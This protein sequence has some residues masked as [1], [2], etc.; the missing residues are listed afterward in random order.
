MSDPQVVRPAEVLGVER[1]DDDFH[2]SAHKALCNQHDAA[3]IRIVELERERDEA[4]DMLN[5]WH[6]LAKDAKP[7]CG[8]IGDGYL[9]APMKEIEFRLLRE[10]TSAFLAK[11]PQPAKEQVE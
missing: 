3:L 4:R 6:E 9:I 7:D 1:P 8:G 10:A 11:H 2:Q 5:D